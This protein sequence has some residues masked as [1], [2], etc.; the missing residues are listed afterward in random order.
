MDHVETIE[1]PRELVTEAADALLLLSLSERTQG[2]AGARTGEALARE[3][4]RE[5]GLPGGERGPTR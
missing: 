2:L 1:L 4:L 5:L 3:P